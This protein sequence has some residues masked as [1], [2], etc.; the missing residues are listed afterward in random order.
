MGHETSQIGKS[1]CFGL[2][3]FSLF[4]KIAVTEDR[5]TE[6]ENVMKKIV[7]LFILTRRSA[8]EIIDDV[9]FS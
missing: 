3:Y 2:R 8:G 6:M 4:R 7:L 9:I 5:R 1:A